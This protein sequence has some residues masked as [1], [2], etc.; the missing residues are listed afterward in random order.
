L[1]DVTGLV[2]P[3]A[4]APTS[5]LRGRSGVVVA[6]LWLAFVLAVAVHQWH[7]WHADRL[8]ADV[9]AL[10]PVDEQAPELVMAT[11]RLAERVSRQ[12]I[13]MLGAPQ[14]DEARQAAQAWRGALGAASS[15]LHEAPGADPAS[16]AAA[17]AYYRPWRDRLLTSAQ[18]EHLAVTPASELT[19]AALAALYQPAA[20]MRL[21]DWVADPLGLWTAWWSA[22]AGDTRARPRDGELW[23]AGEGQ[24][25]VVLRYELTGSAFSLS[26]DPVLDDALKRAEV[27]ARAAAPA[28]QVLKAGVPLHAEAAA[29]AANREINTI[30]WGSLAAV[31]LLVWATFLSPRPVVLVGVSLVVGCACALSVTAWVFG[32]VHLLTLVF[33]ASLVGVA[34]DYGIHYYASRQGHPGVEPRS[35]MRQ[36]LPGL[37][38]ALLTSV[39][40]YLALGVAPFPGLRQMALFSS[41]G[42]LAALLTVVCWFPVLDRAAPRSGCVSRW[43]AASLARCPR[44]NLSRRTG[45]VALVVAGLAVPGLA[46]LTAQD[47]IRQLQN[48]PADLMQSQRRVGALLGAPS[49]AQFYLVRGASDEET[50]QR[51]EALKTRL[52]ALVRE[53]RIAGYAAVSDWVPSMARQRADGELSARVEQQV[54]AGVNATLGERL[55]RPAFAADPLTL[56]QWLEHPVSATGRALWLGDLRGQPTSVVMLRGLHDVHA[57]PLLAAAADGLPGVR[58]VDK[59]AEVSALLGR[60]R[61]S[62]A[63]LLVLGHVLVLLALGRRFGRHAWRA[64]LPTALATGLTLAV[65][66]AL[67]QPVQ[68]FHVLAL[69]L[70]LGV[71]VD[72]GIFLLEHPDDG[73][74]WLA[75]VIGALSTWLSFGLLALSATPALRAFGLTLLIGLALVA[76]LA[77]VLRAPA[78]SPHP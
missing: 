14:W 55:Q 23:V 9:L 29:V 57:L 28:L 52:D 76:G 45:L 46:R 33:G 49:P 22:R 27:A 43:V 3:P 64:W 39:A 47:D 8:D 35:L 7:F 42:L 77:P 65:F 73:S 25:W 24:Q 6:A 30:G 2:H 74:A 26:G 53:G 18:R 21:S 31:L 41:V 1:N 20:R 62:M 69:A 34:E 32:K 54:L 38:C 75:V 12:V 67:G 19:Q 48:S 71:G 60:Y 11:Q 68:L 44:A 17:I 37:V 70:L 50:L 5:R 13:V 78:S 59:T 66:G 15:P 72:Y 40:A 63:W 58:W 61:V 16:M 10:L 51:E 36:L 56:R 4:T